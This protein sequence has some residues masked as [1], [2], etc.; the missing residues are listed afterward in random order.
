MPTE[1]YWAITADYKRKLQG[2]TPTLYNAFREDPAEAVKRSRAGM[3][4]PAPLLA[5]G[6]EELSALGKYQFARS[7]RKPKVAAKPAPKADDELCPEVD[8][9]EGLE[10]D[11]TEGD[12][13]Y[14]DSYRAD[15]YDILGGVA[16]LSI[17]GPMTKKPTSAQWLFGGTSTIMLRAKLA[18]AATNPEVGA[19]LI[20]VNSGGGTVAGTADLADHIARVNA[21]K[22]VEAFVPDVAASAA[23]WAISGCR[24]IWVGR[25]ALVGS[26]GVYMI[27]EDLSK[28]YANAGV[29]VLVFKAGEFKAAG[30]DGTTITKDQRDDFQREVNLLNEEFVASVKTGRNMTDAQVIAINTG[31]VWKGDQLITLKLVDGISRYETVLNDLSREVALA[32]TVKHDAIPGNTS[33][34]GGRGL[35]AEFHAG[36]EP[37]Y[38]KTGDPIEA[39]IGAAIEAEAVSKPLLLINAEHAG[40][41]VSRETLPIASAEDALPVEEVTPAPIDTATQDDATVIPSN[42]SATAE[43]ETQVTPIPGAEDP[44]TTPPPAAQ[45]NNEGTDTM[46]LNPELIAALEKAGITTASQLHNLVAQAADGVFAKSAIINEIKGHATRLQGAAAVDTEGTALPPVDFNVLYGNYPLANL[47][48][49]RD[50]IKGQ[51]DAVFKNVQQA[52]GTAP[53]Q[54]ARTTTAGS[55]LSPAIAGA[56]NA[57]EAAGKVTPDGVPFVDPVAISA[58][59]NDKREVAAAGLSA[60]ASSGR[61]RPTR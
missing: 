35:N 15:D 37:E 45:S 58:M 10:D 40:A 8:D 9:D 50:T 41:N 26:I 52:D 20:D 38:P 19:I 31:Q 34:T 18:H 61:T 47:S 46:E 44:A 60:G 11:G 43:G 14:G 3:D 21:I 28:M 53:A 56:L 6:I 2:M 27:I 1:Q 4:V 17:D 33:A 36:P 51:A 22:P 59:F 7:A 16:L 49:I 5:L 29:E 42:E 54:G 57:S 13:F 25:S 24:K 12:N 39:L 55:S 48:A 30:E 23:Y 32:G